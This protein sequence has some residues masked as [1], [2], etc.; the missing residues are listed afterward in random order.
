MVNYGQFPLS[1]PRRNRQANY[2]RNLTQ[3]NLVT[4]H[5][6]IYPVFVV[7]GSNREEPI[8]SMPG[9]YRLSLDLLL[10]LLDD[11]V[12]IGLQGVALFPVIEQGKD[13]L[14]T[15]S[16]NPDG[17]LPQVV[18][19]IKAKFPTLGIFTDIALD[20][21]TIHGQDGIIDEH[22]YVMNDIT[23]EVLIK[24]A[25]CHAKAGAD[26]VCPSDMMDGRIGLIRKALEENGFHNTGIMAYSA[27]YASKYYGPFRDAVGSATNLGKA[28]KFT[29]QMH[30]ANSNEALREVALDIAEGADMVMVKPGLPYL[31]IVY[32]VKT[33]FKM[34]TAVYHVSGEYAMLK[35]ASQNSWLD[36]EPTLMETML[37]FKRAGA[38]V[39]WT[40][41]A[42]DVLNILRK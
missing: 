9:Q 40:Y 31:D 34:P 32:R 16:Y 23:N 4:A 10:K 11:A 30:P 42:L 25:L 26:F 8:L 21:Y 20:P 14:A 27:K 41:C 7:A 2:I 37:S 6:L 18:K 38:D 3:E 5:D 29:Y 1:R 39:I 28:D 15:E 35:A 17:L 24:Q 33:E 12:A 22:G 36:Y 13:N 19:A